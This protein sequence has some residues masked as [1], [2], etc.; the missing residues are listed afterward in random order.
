VVLGV[1]V[2]RL[3]VPLHANVKLA[4]LGMAAPVQVNFVLY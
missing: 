1:T 2:T 3:T 4:F